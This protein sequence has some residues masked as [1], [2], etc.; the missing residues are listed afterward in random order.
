MQLKATAVNP[1]FVS[2][3]TVAASVYGYCVGRKILGASFDV[4][5]DG[6]E[7][8]QRE[9]PKDSLLDHMVRGAEH[10]A[11]NSEPVKAVAATALVKCIR[12][13]LKSPD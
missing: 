2:S 1:L 10:L 9:H 4:F 5:N 7:R 11:R 6:Y 8:S 3:A 13:L 12:A